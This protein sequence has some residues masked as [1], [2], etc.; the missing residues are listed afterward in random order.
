MPEL[1]NVS[2]DGNATRTITIVF[3]TRGG[4]TGATATVT[5]FAENLQT[6]GSS[7][8][9]RLELP[10]LAGDGRIGASGPNIVIT[11]DLPYPLLAVLITVLACISAGVLLT[12]RR[13]R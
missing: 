13:R 12:K 11:Q 4:G 5:A 10:Q 9:F 3:E 8:T 6:L 7:V 1:G 2:V